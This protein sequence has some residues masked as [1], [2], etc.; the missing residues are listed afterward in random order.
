VSQADQKERKRRATLARLKA[1]QD[2]VDRMHAEAEQ[3]AAAARLGVLNHL[4]EPQ[5]E[6]PLE[7]AG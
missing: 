1:M 5:D 2:E 3:R 7:R 6:L 4:P